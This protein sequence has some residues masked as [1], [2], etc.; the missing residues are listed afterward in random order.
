M[1]S[2]YRGLS[3]L[4]KWQE[5]GRLKAEWCAKY[6]YGDAKAYDAFIDKIVKELGL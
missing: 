3:E 5:Y 4:K 2:K 1:L 6:G